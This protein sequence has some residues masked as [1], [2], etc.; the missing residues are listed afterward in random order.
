MTYFLSFQFNSKIPWKIFFLPLTLGRTGSH[1]LIVLHVSS[2]HVLS[3]FCAQTA[4][5]TRYCG[6]LV[7]LVS[8]K[9]RKN[10]TYIGEIHRNICETF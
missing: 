2:D 7:Q 4:L 5:T 1:G 3:K 9:E 6:F 10:N 8:I